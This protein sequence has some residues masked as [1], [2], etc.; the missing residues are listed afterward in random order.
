MLKDERVQYLLV[1]PGTDRRQ[2]LKEAD[3]ARA[4]MR[5]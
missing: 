5:T 1:P 3:G 2:A 4:F